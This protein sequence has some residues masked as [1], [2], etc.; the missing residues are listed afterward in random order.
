MFQIIDFLAGADD[1]ALDSFSHFVDVLYRDFFVYGSV[2]SD[3]LHTLVEWKDHA[4]LA[5]W[6]LICTKEERQRF[7]ELMGKGY[8]AHA[9]SSVMALRAGNTKR[10]VRIEHDSNL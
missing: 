9:G 6:L 10:K 1:D 8:K 2:Y 4:P 7:A 3:T 5:Q